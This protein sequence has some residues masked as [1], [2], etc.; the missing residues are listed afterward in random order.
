MQL[1]G[2]KLFLLSFVPLCTYQIPSTSTNAVKIN[3]V[4]STF[5][6]HFLLNLSDLRSWFAQDS[7]RLCLL[8][9]HNY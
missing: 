5:S 6:L 1:I 4:F 9:W 8:S 3:I 2:Q 7:P